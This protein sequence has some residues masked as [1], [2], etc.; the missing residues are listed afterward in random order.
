MGLDQLLACL[1]VAGVGPCRGACRAAAHPDRRDRDPLA[2][3]QDQTCRPAV[4]QTLRYLDVMHRRPRDRRRRADQRRP[5]DVTYGHLDTAALAAQMH[6]EAR[7]AEDR[8]QDRKSTRLN[9]SHVA[10]SYAVFC[11]TKKK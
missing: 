1:A 10:I 2:I 5:M 7:G 4:A 11:L 3:V 9:S 8:R 6:E